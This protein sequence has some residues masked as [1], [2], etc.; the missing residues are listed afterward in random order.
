MANNIPYQGY[1]APGASAIRNE[2]RGRRVGPSNYQQGGFNINASE[3]G[4]TNIETLGF[5]SSTDGNNGN[6]GTYMAK[7]SFPLNTANTSQN[8]VPPTY[9]VVRYYYTANSVEVA[10]NTDLSGTVT[11][12]TAT[13]L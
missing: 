3:L 6:V 2:W 7:A 12:M 13:G 9:A 1:P 11:L 5:G 8:A 10:N 4:M